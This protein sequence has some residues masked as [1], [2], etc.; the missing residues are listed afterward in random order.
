MKQNKET[1]K[2]FFETGDKPTQQQYYDLIDSYV[3]AKQPEG[4]ANRRFVIDETGEV[5]VASELTVSQSDWNQTDSTQPDFIKNKPEG[6]LPVNFYEEGTF[7][8]I[9]VDTGGGATYTIGTTNKGIYTRLGNTVRFTI[10]V[11]QI[12]T[13]NTPTGTVEIEGLPFVT[14]EITPVT[15]GQIYGGDVN[16]YSCNAQIISNK[17]GFNV[18]TGFDNSNG[19]SLF[20]CTFTGGEIMISGTYQ[21]NVYTP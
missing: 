10:N 20:Q 17:I 2:Q 19:T 4:E 14:S 5:S 9:L 12:N 13:I 7:T 16:F 1:L 21:T 8:P 6:G 11:Q 3:D 15:V 18:Q